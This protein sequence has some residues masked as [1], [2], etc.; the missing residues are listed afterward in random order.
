MLGDQF[1]AETAT[2]EAR[3]WLAAQPAPKLCPH[4]QYPTTSRGRCLRY[5]E[6]AELCPGETG[7]AWAGLP[8]I[9]IDV[10]VPT[11]S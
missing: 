5:D 7:G 1:D 3:A 4:C 10:V 6:L 8:I 2:A 11:R 9:T